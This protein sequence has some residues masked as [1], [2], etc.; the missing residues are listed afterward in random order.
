MTMVSKMSIP[1]Q[2]SHSSCSFFGRFHWWSIRIEDALGH[3]KSF[4][5]A[6]IRDISS[7]GFL[8]FDVWSLTLCNDIWSSFVVK[9]PWATLEAS[10]VVFEADV[11]RLNF[12]FADT[13]LSFKVLDLDEVLATCKESINFSW[14]LEERC[15][16]SFGWSKDFLDEVDAESCFLFFKI[17]G[18][19]SLGSIHPLWW[20]PIYI[21]AG[22]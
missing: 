17:I 22:H 13:S 21:L 12:D 10:E 19:V 8:R 15:D 5:E 11:R 18:E 20:P 7:Q 4:S 14:D 3:P 2:A 16:F 9:E 6:Y 1:R